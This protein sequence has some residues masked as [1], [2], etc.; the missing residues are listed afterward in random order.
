MS[1]ARNA[2]K[3]C[4]AC[5]NPVKSNVRY[6]ASCYRK[7]RR[8]RRLTIADT[9]APWAVRKMIEAGVITLVEAQ[10]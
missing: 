3:K 1:R 7:R 6:C 5:G 4:R 8:A 9:F 2:S 10:K